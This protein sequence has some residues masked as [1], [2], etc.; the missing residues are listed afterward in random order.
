MDKNKSF[1]SSTQH[2]SFP[3]ID[4]TQEIPPLVDDGKFSTSV[5]AMI[6]LLENK[7]IIT[8][9]L[10]SALKTDDDIEN[11]ILKKIE[12]YSD[13]DDI[14]EIF[15]LIQIWGGITGRGIYVLD[16]QFDWSKIAI[17]YHN[18]VGKC[19]A[20]NTLC[21]KSID[22]LISAIEK[23]NASVRHMGAAYITKHTRYWLY[24]S[25]GNNALPIYD[26][27]MAKCVMQKNSA[28]LR[29]LSEYWKAMISKSKELGISLMAL[30]RHI[31][32]HEYYQ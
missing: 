11:L 30:E 21:D 26:R 25:M 9:G 15:H 14:E 6:T 27:I 7:G 16:G 1:N 31:F 18:L 3:K 20:T 13:S 22:A 19:L 10:L 2:I 28:Q 8:K 5:K 23:F 17:H 32:K 12:G 4:Y 29:D 24:R